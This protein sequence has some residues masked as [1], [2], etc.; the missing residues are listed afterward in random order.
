MT[1]NCRNHGAPRN[2]SGIAPRRP[3]KAGQ[4]GTTPSHDGSPRGVARHCHGRHCIAMDVAGPSSTSLLVD[5][6]ARRKVTPANPS[7]ERPSTRRPGQIRLDLTQAHYILA[8][9]GRPR[10]SLGLQSTGATTR[11]RTADPNAA[12]GP[13]RMTA[14]RGV[15]QPTASRGHGRRPS[16]SSPCPPPTSQSAVGEE[17]RRGPRVPS[18]IAPN[19]LDPPL[20]D[21]WRDPAATRQGEIPLLPATSGL[22]PAVKADGG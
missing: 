3:L 18:H 2:M 1:A 20:P 6:W 5:G 19:H 13:E 15:A 17:T 12:D 21:G 7:E 10:P 9:D 14:G 11:R 22:W 4:G 16:R 8:R